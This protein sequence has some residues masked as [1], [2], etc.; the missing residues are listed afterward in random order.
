MIGYLKNY[1]TALL[2]Q[3]GYRAPIAVK[4]EDQD[5]ASN[6]GG[7]YIKMPREHLELKLD[8][9]KPKKKAV[10]V[11]KGLM[12]HEIGHSLQ[13]LDEIHE[14][15]QETGLHHAFVNLILDVQLERVALKV[16]K[17]E[18][19]YL[20]AWRKLVKRKMFAS[21][22]SDFAKLEKDEEEA[23]LAG[24]DDRLKEIFGTQAQLVNLI[25]RFAVGKRPYSAKKKVND[26]V[27]SGRLKEYHKLVNK[28][29]IKAEALPRFLRYVARK[30][31]E[32]C[33]P[34][35]QLP[36]FP[37]MRTGSFGGGLPKNS[38]EAQELAEASQRINDILETIYLDLR[39]GRPE[40]E[41]VKLAAKLRMQLK[42]APATARIIAPVT[43]NRRKLAIGDDQPWYM[44]VRRG[45]N[46]KRHMTIVFD[47][48]ASMYA[49]N[50][51]H[52]AKVASQAI[53][54][55]VESAGGSVC[56]GQ[57][58]AYGVLSAELD[59]S[60]LFSGVL[61]KQVG[62]SFQILANVWLNR[63]LDTIIVITD[64]AGVLPDLIKPADRERTHVICLGGQAHQGVSAL[65][66]VHVL[67]DNELDLLPQIMLDMI[68]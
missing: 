43:M 33:N 40:P 60:P 12:V 21:Y 51:L 18:A 35:L 38:D 16:W 14:V 8:T 31:P 58:G 27:I 34:A 20:V 41:A 56:G 37:G 9:L 46:I 42:V 1:G 36:D 2:R 63:P 44:D 3:V 50:R 53:C 67:G 17:S 23:T 59:A 10:W 15:E 65:G 28:T 11:A 30:F 29:P 52:N 22:L 61:A 4:W 19:K 64:G 47:V 24:D 6:T 13:P 68:N 26:T 39:R 7:L 62:T 49:C 66:D 32:L 45:N 48:S 57:F 5:T 25:G 55:A 54:L